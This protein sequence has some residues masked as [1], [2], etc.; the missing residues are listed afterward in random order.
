MEFLDIQNN[1]EVKSLVRSR[2]ITRIKIEDE[3]YVPISNRGYA[4]VIQDGP[5]SLLH[6]RR[7]IIQS[8][9]TDGYGRSNPTAAADN[10]GSV[11]GI[12]GT[13]EPNVRPRIEES[14]FL[15][16]DRKIRRASR[17][18]YLRFY[19]EIKPQIRQF[20]SEHPVDFRNKEHLRGLSKFSNGLILG[21]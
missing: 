16:K 10:L 14:F 12:S 18:N 1:D 7:V 15:M 2:N 17:K 4:K 5:V 21:G 20:L 19:P 13:F 3:V 9:K 6:S 8:D 11:R